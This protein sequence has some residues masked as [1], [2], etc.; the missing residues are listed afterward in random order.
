MNNCSTDKLYKCIF[1][2]YTKKF[3][4]DKSD[5]IDNNLILYTNTIIK[6]P[7]FIYFLDKYIVNIDISM[8][9]EDGI[10]E[11]SLLYVTNNHLEKNYIASIYIDKFYSIYNNINNHIDNTYLK[12]ALINN[13]FDPR[14]VA[15][16]LPY[17]LC[18][19][20]WEKI[21]N[22]YETKKMREQNII[23]TD[24]YQ[25]GKCKAKRATVFF[26]QTRSADE[27]MTIFITCLGCGH[28]FRK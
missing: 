6:R 2:N 17:Q 9:I 8:G 18:P 3:V 21:V 7:I 12:N 20:K 10:Y 25:C 4:I 19:N 5:D 15:F 22:K 24:L 26:Q 27:P 23:S 14:F 28:Q 16:M 11:F 1:S 13:N